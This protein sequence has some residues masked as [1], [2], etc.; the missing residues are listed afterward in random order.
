VHANVSLLRLEVS[1]EGTHTNAKS[2]D[3][4]VNL[5]VAN[6]GITLQQTLNSLLVV[7]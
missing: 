4:N 1:L 5:R 6:K 7:L 2:N 3:A